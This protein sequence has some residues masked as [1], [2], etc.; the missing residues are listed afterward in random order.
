MRFGWSGG[1]PFMTPL[2]DAVAERI[3]QS[4][5]VDLVDTTIDAVLSSGHTLTKIE[6]GRYHLDGDEKALIEYPCTDIL[7]VP[8]T[9]FAYVPA[10][11]WT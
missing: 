5:R 7:F 3:G 9:P 4:R 11:L 6:H 1:Y 8:G 10:G 2:L